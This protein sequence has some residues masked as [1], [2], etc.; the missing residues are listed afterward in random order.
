MMLRRYFNFLLLQN[1][2]QERT[3]KED[4]I[5]SILSGDKYYNSV[6]NSCLSVQAAALRYIYR[7]INEPMS[8]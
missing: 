2:N 6:N 4:S 1:S 5:K 8:L 3:E 7:R